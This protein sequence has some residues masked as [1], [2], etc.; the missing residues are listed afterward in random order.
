AQLDMEADTGGTRQPAH[1]RRQRAIAQHLVP[2]RHLHLEDAVAPRIGWRA[3][4]SAALARRD[5]ALLGAMVLTSGS[6]FSNRLPCH[7]RGLR[8]LATGS[9]V[10]RDRRVLRQASTRVKLPVKLPTR[11]T[12]R[13]MANDRRS[14]SLARCGICLLQH[15][16]PRAP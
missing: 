2:S 7:Q 14:R 15:A 5:C 9:G 12:L 3:V 4:A 13:R 11:T 6:T 1:E 16:R 10:L 8:R